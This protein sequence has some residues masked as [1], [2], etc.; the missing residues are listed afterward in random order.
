MSVP[1]VAALSVKEP[2]VLAPTVLAAQPTFCHGV[3]DQLRADVQVRNVDA[4]AWALSRANNSGADPAARCRLLAI[5]VV[6]LA[7]TIYPFRSYRSCAKCARFILNALALV[8]FWLLQGTN[9]CRYLT[10]LLLI[11]TADGNGV[12]L[13]FCLDALRQF[14]VDFVAKTQVHLERIAS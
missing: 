9:L 2:L 3:V 13:H 12:L 5:L 4:E 14:V 10:N 1:T 8:R 6:T 11:N 7:M